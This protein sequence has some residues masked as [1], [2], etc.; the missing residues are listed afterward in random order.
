MLSRDYR[1]DE[2]RELSLLEL[3]L[4]VAA[5]HVAVRNDFEPFN[6]EM[7]FHGKTLLLFLHLLSWQYVSMTRSHASIVSD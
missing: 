2:L 6:F 5:S 7:V 3:C 1:V 4:V